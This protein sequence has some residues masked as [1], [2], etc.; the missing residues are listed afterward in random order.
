MENKLCFLACK[1][2]EKELQAV[3]ESE[4]FDGVKAVA[5]SSRCSTS[6]AK[7][8]E[9]KSIADAIEDC[10]TFHVLGGCC[11]SG[12]E[13]GGEKIE[14]F[15]FHKMSQC[16]HL[17]ADQNLIDDYI[18]KGFYLLTSGFLEN[19]QNWIDE[20]G[21]DKELAQEF[22]NESQK[23]LLLLDTGVGE[24]SFQLLRE[25]ADF[26][27]R[28]SQVTR[29]GLGFFRLLVTKTV[30]GWRMENEKK[31]L[32]VKLNNARKQSSEYAMALDLLGSLAQTRSE[33]ETVQKILDTFDML[34]APKNLYYLPLKGE[35]PGKIQQSA[36]SSPSDCESIQHRLTHFAKEYAW[37][38]SGSGFTLKIRRGNK[39][40]GAL[41]ADGI[42]FPEYKE[43]YLNLAL[44]I[45]DICGLVIDNANA[46]Q[47]ITDQ[48]DNLEQI[49]KKL[50]ETQK[51]LVESEKMASLGSLV[52]GVAHEINTP[53][54]IG[55]TAASTI[56]ERNIQISEL[57]QNQRMKQDDLKRYLRF[58]HKTGSLILGNLQRTGDLI[59]NFK[60]VSVDQST[61]QR[62]LF[63]LKSY[64]E[65]VILSLQ[66]KLKVKS[67]T[68][69]IDC[70][71]NLKLDSYPGLFAQIMV[72][73]SINSFHHGFKDKK[74][75]EIHIAA[76]TQNDSLHL[77]YRDNGKGIPSDILPKI[78]DP[79]FSTDQQ[80]GT[81]LGLHIIYNIVTQK[82]NGSI[83]CESEIE[84]GVLFTIVMPLCKEGK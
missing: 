9:L 22:F 30:R 75:G 34:F 55:I 35:K 27:G 64:L 84:N 21:F 11:I 17:F 54:G 72:N 12:L 66:P 40:L 61:E 83:S 19:W 69:T 62:R 65:N 26:V 20:Q 29:V 24:D 33:V 44:A 74:E 6:S 68:F 59:Q 38:E 25:F 76:N 77:Q 2:F 41:E 49:L 16:F 42:T 82:L 8:D 47:Q 51:H 48:K 52:A 46:Y 23:H 50:R 57:F 36:S 32:S 78:F 58:I 3:V 45:V 53:V 67:I 1:N 7:W 28:P 5:F 4:Q 31:L 15:H 14:K 56:I 63:G 43:H 18:R 70:D 37:T 10:N 81:G 39:I 60:Q 79:F 73:L 71:K 13:N 80:L